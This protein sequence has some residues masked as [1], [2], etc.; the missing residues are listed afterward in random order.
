MKYYS[1][2]K[3]AIFVCAMLG[4][5]SF[6]QLIVPKVAA[7]GAT[8]ALLDSNWDELFDS[9]G[10]GLFGLLAQPLGKVIYVQPDNRN[11]LLVTFILQGANPST[12]YTVGFSIFPPPFPPNCLSTFGVPL[13]LCPSGFFGG[14]DASSGG[15]IVGKLTTDQDGDGS[16]HVNLKNLP[17]GT[18]KVLFWVVPCF[19]STPCGVY[20]DVPQASTGSAG[21]GPF[22]MITIP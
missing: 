17:S 22:E 13:Y 16:R 5:F 11:K 3:A 8:Q 18:Y 21:F 4:F 1:K 9:N 19:P 14:Y 12:D 6:G 20:S 7:Q 15:Y 2:K 10:D